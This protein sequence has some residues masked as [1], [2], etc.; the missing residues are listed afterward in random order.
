MRTHPFSAGPLRFLPALLVAFFLCAAA[1]VATPP[2]TPEASRARAVLQFRELH[3]RNNLASLSTE[4]APAGQSALDRALARAARLSPDGSW[5]DLDYAS[6]A[7]SGW[8]PHSHVERILEMATAAVDAP[9]ADRARLHEAVHRA[10]AWW[11]AHDYQCTNWWYNEIGVPRIL[12]TAGLV[13]G[14]ALLPAERAYLTEVSLARHPI[15]MT[16][17]NRI[18][19]A[20]N[21]LMRGLLTGE[22]ALV[23]EAVAVIWDEVRVT[24]DEGIQPDFSFHQHGA[25]QQFGNYGQA[26][27]GDIA[28]W[29]TILRETRW[30]LSTERLAIFR[31]YLLQGQ[32]WI[33]WRGAMDISACGRQLMPRR[34]RAKAS[35]IRSVMELAVH[36][37]PA[38]A[39]AYRS[40]IARHERNAPNDL[41]GTRHFWRSDYLIHRRP[42][43]AATLK[44]SSK[45]VIGAELVNSENLSGYH[46]ADGAL[47]LYRTGDEYEEIFPLWDWRKIPGITALQG[48]LP[49]FKTSAVPSD[50][51]GGLATPDGGVSVL[52]LAR[53]GLRARKAWIFHGDTIVC[54]GS[55]I[56]GESSAPAATTLN[57]AHLRGAVTVRTATGQ[58]SLK[59]GTHT[60]KA[61]EFVEHDGWRYTFLTPAD[62]RLELGPVTGNWRKVFNNPS[63]PKADVTGPLFTL[64]IEHGVKPQ[65]A[66]YAY[67]ISPAGTGELPALLANTPALQGVQ[68]APGRFAFVCWEPGE[69]AL[70]GRPRIHFSQPCLG[71]LEGDRLNLV[72][73]TQKLA[74]LDLRIGGRT[75]S[76]E[77][78]SGPLAGT[79]ATLD[80]TP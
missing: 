27:A 24:T 15:A 74:R 50:F 1:S 25:Q 22:T 63:T 49:A 55:D 71:W 31:D 17:Q 56:R 6:T 52:D 46:T 66:T 38:H 78:P 32:N 26:F 39:A 65:S 20:G 41:L 64:W 34:P 37:D 23:D 54:L 8:A 53:A 36:F 75:V 4:T 11:I 69:V 77:L 3:I 18:W 40:Y 7:R 61:P 10:F 59:A 33:A 60:L 73:P 58:Q 76:V 44:L 16:G 2:T 21:Q 35:A 80:L 45:R 42:D 13:L 57:Q 30:Q 70:P 5:P 67:A 48:E 12:G 19:L 62:A 43:F 9:E 14:D 28:R 79:A 47:Y 68:L 29:A 72:D 51:V